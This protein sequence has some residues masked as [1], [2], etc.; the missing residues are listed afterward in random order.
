GGR[1]QESAMRGTFLRVCV[2]VVVTWFGFSSAAYAGADPRKP[3]ILVILA[4]DMGF[5]DVGVH[6]CKDIPTPHIDS[7]A[8]Q[9]VLC[10][11]GYISAPQ[12][13]PT[14]AGLL[15]GRYQQRFGPESNA[16][17]P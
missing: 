9:G 6:G 13:S 3:N 12:C 5:A 10:R 14:R 11:Q 4:D 17:K 8:K 1:L 15:T 2:G 16:A 7:L